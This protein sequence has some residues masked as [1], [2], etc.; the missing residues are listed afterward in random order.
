MNDEILCIKVPEDIFITIG[1]KKLKKIMKLSTAI[2]L[3]KDGELSLGKAAEL[4]DVPKLEFMEI[5]SKEG[6][7]VIDYLPSDLKKEI[8]VLK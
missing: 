4:A 3:F 1:K 7:S 5:L 6:I 2:K 8:N